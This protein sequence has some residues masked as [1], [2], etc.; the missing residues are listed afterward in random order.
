[1][2]LA[3]GAVAA[4]L[5]AKTAEVGVDDV[6]AAPRVVNLVSQFPKGVPQRG[7]KYDPRQYADQNDGSGADGGSEAV[8]LTRQVC[9]PA[10]HVEPDSDA[11][12]S[13]RGTDGRSHVAD[14]DR[15]MLSQGKHNDRLNVVGPQELSGVTREIGL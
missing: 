6:S 8:R 4:I 9:K 14:D 7:P 3:A 12:R 5:L 15:R 11:T 1:M 13:H 2:L 10:L